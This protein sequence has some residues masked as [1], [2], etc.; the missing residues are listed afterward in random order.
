MSRLVRVHRDPRMRKTDLGHEVLKGENDVF[1]LLTLSL[2]PSPSPSLSFSLS[3]PLS[4][5]NVS[6]FIGSKATRGLPTQ[7]PAQQQTTTWAKQ[8]KQPPRSAQP[9]TTNDSGSSWANIASAPKASTA[10]NGAALEDAGWGTTAPSNGNDASHAEPILDHNQE[11]VQPPQP[12]EADAPANDSAH[13]PPTA[14]SK[15]W[16]SL[17]K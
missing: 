14:P 15:T 4:L 5:Y 7:R 8:S 1:R 10:T 11:N 12:P 13:D 2:S 3:L 17:L 6:H 16:A 9:S